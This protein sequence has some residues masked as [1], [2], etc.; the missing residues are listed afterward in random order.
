[1]AFFDVKVFNPIAKRYVHMDT[2]KANQL[3]E[4]EKKKHYNEC[5][6]EGEHGTFSPIVMSAYGVIRKEAKKI[7]KRLAELLTEKKNQQISVMT[8]WFRK[9]LIF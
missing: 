3:N 8:S 9:K 6:L 2:S 5:I 1:M 7:Y 4:K